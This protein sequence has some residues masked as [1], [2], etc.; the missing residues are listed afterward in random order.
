MKEWII[1]VLVLIL[2]GVGWI[3][4]QTWDRA[5]LAEHR[6]MEAEYQASF[7]ESELRQLYDRLSDD[8]VFSQKS[9][10]EFLGCGPRG[11]TA[12]FLRSAGLQAAS[13][14]SLE[15]GVLAWLL[16]YLCDVF[17]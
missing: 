1:L 3:L 10:M 13:L 9:L 12:D 11:N 5:E 2:A 4:V 7:Y 17:G 6:A 16:G 14:G 15:T 8:P